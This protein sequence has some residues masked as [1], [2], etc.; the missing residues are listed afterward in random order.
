M[1][2]WLIKICGNESGQTLIEFAL[3]ASL[4]ILILAGIVDYSIYIR[5]E[6]ELT[7]AAA[8]GA[9][10]GAYPGQQENFGAMST[11]AASS[12]P[13]VSNVQ[14]T[15]VDVYSCT[16]GGTAV[17]STAT[18]PSGTPLM[19]VKVTTTGTV[20][21]VLVWTGISSSLTLHGQAMYRVPWTQ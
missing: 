18:C 20:P 4:L 8:A 15:A 19:Y 2:S 21:A 7:E 14:V 12:A 11:I 5:D 1:R 6:M 10:L 3:F 9:G 17:A 16:P 13:D